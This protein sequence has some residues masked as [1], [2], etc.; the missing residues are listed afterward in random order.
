MKSALF[1]EHANEMP[2]S[3]SCEEDCYCKFHSCRIKSIIKNLPSYFYEKLNNTIEEKINS[4]TYF[5]KIID[6]LE[7]LSEKD[8][9][10]LSQTPFLEDLQ[11]L[12]VHHLKPKPEPIDQNKLISDFW[13]LSSTNQSRILEN[14]LGWSKTQ[15]RERMEDFGN[16]CSG[17]ILRDLKT[18]CLLRDFREELDKLC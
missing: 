10:L 12:I 14:I 9:E 8:E 3:C 5:Q 13:N 4:N 2:M 17:I 7:N 1:C 6:L 11:N 15:I 18:K 16:N